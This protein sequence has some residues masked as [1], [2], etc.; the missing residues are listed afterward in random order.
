MRSIISLRAALA[1]ACDDS[2]DSDDSDDSA[3][4]RI[5]RGG[6]GNTGRYTFNPADLGGD[7]DDDNDDDDDDDDGGAQHYVA[8]RAFDG[9]GPDD[10]PLLVGD[11]VMVTDA[12][13]AEWWVGTVDGVE[14]RFPAACVVPAS[15]A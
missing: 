9:P 7:D 10:L 4:P 15:E 13:D 11:D 14:G 6:P 3:T 12:A 5:A 1:A 2:N 8:V